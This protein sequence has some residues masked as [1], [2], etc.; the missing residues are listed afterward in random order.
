MR[1]YILPFD[2]RDRKQAA[3]ALE[4]LPEEWKAIDVL[5]NNA[6]LVIGVDKEFEGSLDEWDI[7]IDTN[8]RGLLAMTRMVEIG[9]A[10]CRER[11]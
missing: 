4:S 5:V 6:G 1:V 3:A 11:V 7:M 2:V 9:R 10:S 8:I